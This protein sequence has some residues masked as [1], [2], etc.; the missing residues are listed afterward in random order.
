MNNQRT[1]WEG[2][3]VAW[4]TVRGQGALQGAHSVDAGLL[5]EE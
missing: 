1:P 3:T 4:A 5:S 2:V